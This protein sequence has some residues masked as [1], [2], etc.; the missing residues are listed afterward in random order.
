MHKA[1]KTQN[2]IEMW[3]NMGIQKRATVWNMTIIWSII[4]VLFYNHSCAHLRLHVLFF[5]CFFQIAFTTVVYPS[6]LIGYIR[7]AAHLSKNLDDI[8]LAFFESVSGS[9]FCLVHYSNKIINFQFLDEKMIK[10]NVILQS[11]EYNLSLTYMM[12][13]GFLQSLFFGHCLW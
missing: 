12:S 4:H 2:G 8:Q 3:F 13:T 11:S 1:L 7:Q 6:L 5:S 9:L 10:F